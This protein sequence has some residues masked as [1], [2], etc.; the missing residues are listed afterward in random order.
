MTSQYKA[1]IYNY[2]FNSINA[3]LV[4]VN[5]IVMVPIYFHYMSVSTYG[6]WLATGNVIS[7]LGLLEGGFSF[8]I[9]QKLS[10][11]L[12]QKD[13]HRYQVLSGSNILTA[14]AISLGILILG[15]SIS[16]FITDWVNVESQ[17]VEEI[18]WAF[19]LSLIATSISIFIN[20]YGS[21]PQVWQDTKSV[22]IFNTI[23]NIAAI[24]FL[25][26]FLFCGF[27]V[28]SI[29]ASFIVRSLVNAVSYTL[30][31][32]RNWK[33]RGYPKPIYS[34]N[35][36]VQL[37]K[38]CIYPM[39]SKIAGT[40]VG[41]SQSFIIAHF[42][43]PGLAAIYDLTSKIC[44]VACGFVAQMNGAFFALFSFTLAEGNKEKI[45]KVM[46]NT[47]TFFY[48]LL[49]TTVLYSI[50]FSE[51]MINY[52]VGLDKFG[53]TALL[54]VLVI[55][56]IFAQIREYLNSILYT[57][58]MISKSAK[59]DILWMIIYILMLVGSIK[60]LQIYAVPVA[61]LVS[62]FIFVWVYFAL[63]KKYLNLDILTLITL[64]VRFFIL[65]IPFIILHF[66]F[67]L[68]YN[69][70][71]LYIAYFFVFSLSYI[72]AL[73]FTNKHFFKMLIKK[74]TKRI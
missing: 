1:S 52:W 66:F 59:Y 25:I 51:P 64:F 11:A 60:L 10:A 63:A 42:M 49:A 57:G 73:Y 26:I 67:A 62:C 18:R 47:F 45:D 16:P 9:T 61:T 43:N 54:V 36:A 55:A 69:N 48:V 24:I 21:F 15:F 72:L 27:G 12:A 40:V 28:I 68:D 39:L 4:I 2:V 22:G 23:A 46:K 6:A 65:I 50:C 35:D 14:F 32:V 30:W 53:G 33:L 74:I 56:K 58:G 38:D 19:I 44:M 5:G 70:L 71:S 8:V 3:F 7:I 41:N 13:M 31:I 17:V 29:A 37:T 20:L 34:I